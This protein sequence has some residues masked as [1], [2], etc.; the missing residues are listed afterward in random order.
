[1]CDVT[2]DNFEEALAR[3]RKIVPQSDFVSIDLEFTGLD[4]DVYND[5]AASSEGAPAGEP[6]ASAAAAAG[7]A[8]A[9]AAAGSK[10]FGGAAGPDATAPYDLRKEAQ[11]KYSKM[12]ETTKFLVVQVCAAVKCFLCILHVCLAFRIPVW[13]FL[14]SSRIKFVRG[15]KQV[16][17]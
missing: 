10:W 4:Q 15:K 16:R 9:G 11:A 8:A 14:R 2:V 5:A 17:R 13:C 6:A 7:G 3:L 12:R 1:M